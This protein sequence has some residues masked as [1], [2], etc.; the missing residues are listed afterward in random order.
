MDGRTVGRK[1]VLDF[2]TCDEEGFLLEPEFNGSIVDEYGEEV[3]WGITDKNL[4]IS[5]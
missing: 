2:E 1:M 5:Q 4:R 3:V